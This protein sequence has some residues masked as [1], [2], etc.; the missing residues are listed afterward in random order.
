MLL[1]KG[2][3][4]CCE[5]P[6]EKPRDPNVSTTPPNANTLIPNT[7]SAKG[8]DLTITNRKRN[9]EVP[10]ALS[11]TVLLDSCHCTGTMLRTVHGPQRYSLERMGLLREDGRRMIGEWELWWW[12]EEGGSVGRGGRGEGGSETGGRD[13]GR[14]EGTEG[15][16]ER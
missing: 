16:G 4:C 8:Q 2:Q 5:K 15:E 14:E 6:R 11:Y 9:K 13:G 7:I 1:P 10:V 12:V 3:A